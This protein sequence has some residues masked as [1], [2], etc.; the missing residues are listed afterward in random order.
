MGT[1]PATFSGTSTYAADLQQEITHAVTVASLPLNGLEANVSA[2]QS[3]SN[4]LSTLQGE[5]GSLL[6][7]IQNLDQAN[8]GGSLSASVSADTVATATLDSAAAISGG[9]YTLHVINAGS[10]TTTIS[11]STLPTVADPTS[12][13]SSSSFTL[14]VGTS[15]FTINP[16]AS[17]LDA[18]AQAINA[19]NAGGE[20]DARE[21]GLSFGSQLPLVPPEFGASSV[22]IQLYDG[23]QNLLNTPT[24]GTPAS[25]QVNGE[26]STPISSDSD[27]IT[28]AP[29]LTANLLTPGDTTITVA[30]NPSSAANALSA[31]CRLITRPPAS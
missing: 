3:Q 15:T 26:P 14:T 23:T 5:F 11:E 18:L 20:R 19:A 25:Y 30:S 31:S 16:L 6:S 24:T 27:T 9:T 7:A 28:L 17:N 29:G 13:S 8:N 4:E 22:D 10:P 2:L 12:I 21:S 1:T